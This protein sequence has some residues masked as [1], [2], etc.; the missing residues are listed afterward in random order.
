MVI[1]KK[2]KKKYISTSRCVT[3]FERVSKCLLS[4]IV[5][6]VRRAVRSETL[7]GKRKTLKSDEKCYDMCTRL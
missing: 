1:V 4:L 5:D 6:N 2:G 3:D 7:F